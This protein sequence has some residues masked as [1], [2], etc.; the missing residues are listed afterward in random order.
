MTS[1]VS[2]ADAKALINTSMTDE[3]LQKVI[4]RIEAQVT[5]RIGAPWTDDTTPSQV[6]KTMR[7]EG[8]SLFFPTEIHD[9][10]SIVEDDIELTADEY[11]QWA[12]GVLERL[13]MNARWGDVCVVTYQPADDRLKREQ[14]IISL[15]RL[16]LERTAMKSESIAGE[17][18]Y[19]APDNW[20]AEF[21]MAMKRLTFMAV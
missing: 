8:M 3:N 14:V 13:P 2:P 19:T 4:D 7:G 12:G 1:L 21:R 9:V 17:Y 18:S 5:K 11:R 15:V 16:T 6:V 10:V 20:D